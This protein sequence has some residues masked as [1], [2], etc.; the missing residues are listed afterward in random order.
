MDTLWRSLNSLE[1]FRLWR[2]DLND[3]IISS[4]SRTPHSNLK[5]L[6]LCSISV[7][8]A[9]SVDIWDDFFSCCGKQLTSLS[10]SHSLLPPRLGHVIARHCVRL[11]ELVIR[12]CKFTD[13]SIVAVAQ[14]RGRTLKKIKLYD[15]SFTE[16]S[17]RV[18]C[19][20]CTQLE[21]LVLFRTEHWLQ[22]LD[23]TPLIAY[24]AEH[25]NLLRS[26]CV[27]GWRTTN[28]LL[29]S[30]ARYG[31]NLQELDFENNSELK[32]ALLQKVMKSCKLRQLNITSRN[33]CDGL[34]PE[35]I[36][37]VDKHYVFAKRIQNPL[38]LDMETIY[39]ILYGSP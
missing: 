33:D 37:L 28:G 32:D 8:D 25:G 13:T 29:D 17:L 16:Q 18:I 19:E 21:E 39:G 27:R 36:T 9:S 24:M 34:S 26:L 3:T 31:T 23:T 4:W 11:E 10:I 5:T 38:A 7:V 30:L 22:P 35:L 20:E 1:S 12:S 15:T 14:Q 2:V 6:D